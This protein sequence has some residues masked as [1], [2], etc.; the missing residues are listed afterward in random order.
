MQGK[1]D[2]K[3]S[4]KDKKGNKHS[5]KHKS[6]KVMTDAYDLGSK[7]HSTAALPRISYG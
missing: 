7:L 6:N 4:E 3:P 1:K 5:K 2:K